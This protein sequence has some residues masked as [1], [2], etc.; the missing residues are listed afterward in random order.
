MSHTSSAG[1]D[2]TIDDH[3]AYYAAAGD[4]TAAWCADFEWSYADLS[5]QAGAMPPAWLP[6][7]SALGT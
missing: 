1:D 6:L 2:S 4:G 7:A 3:I 5:D